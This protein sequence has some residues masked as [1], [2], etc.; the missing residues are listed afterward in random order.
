MLNTFNIVIIIIIVILGLSFL[1][2]FISRGNKGNKK[3][4]RSKKDK[5]S[6]L[7]EANRK[8]LQNPRDPDALQILASIAFEEED[9]ENAFKYYHTLIELVATNPEI[10]EFEVTLRYAISA[11]KLKKLQEAYKSFMIARTLKPENFEVNY[12]LGYLE[13]LRKN[14]DKSTPLLKKA[15]ILN[16][17]HVDTIRY[18]AHSLFRS[19]NYSE[20]IKYFRKLLE[21][22][23]EDKNALFVLGQSYYEL[24]QNE[25]AIKI[26]S[27]LR[28]N[29][30][31]GPNASLLAGSLRMKAKQ[32]DKAITDF[33]IGLKHENIRTEIKLELL[34]RLAT[35]YLKTNSVENAIQ[36][37]NEILKINP[38]YKDTKELIAK[39]KEISANKNLQIYLMAT[40][41][42]FIGLCRRIA[43]NFFK[44]SLTKL[45]NINLHKNEYVDI[46]AEVSTKKWEDVVL[47]RFVRGTGMV[48]ELMLRDLYARMKEVKA[49]RGICITAGTFSEGAKSF[50]EAR[51]ID[52]IEEKQLLKIFNSLPQSI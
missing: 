46:L 42:E 8:L 40:S 3:K 35:V 19:K 44:K 48:G 29:P 52:L 14:Y 23:P 12:N 37:W 45:T 31:L 2:F 34:Y 5:N 39:Y 24:G 38:D 20:A 47:F 50:V 6:L 25:N 26:F 7:K 49:G 43:L 4:T 17:E 41:S 16:P 22:D 13:L 1:L 9:Y 51:L 33:E 36:T 32:F 10:D 11:L 28:T 30:Q 18:L 27:H 21:Y 15:N